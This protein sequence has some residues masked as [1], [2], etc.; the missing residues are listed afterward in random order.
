MGLELGIVSLGDSREDEL[1]FL[2]EIGVWLK[3]HRIS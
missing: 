2:E 1:L 3:A